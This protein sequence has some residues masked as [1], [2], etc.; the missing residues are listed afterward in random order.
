M[1]FYYIR[2]AQSANNALWDTTGASKG[3]N[4][5]PDITDTGREQAKLLADF[6]QRTD[7]DAAKSGKGSVLKRDYF[8]FTHLYTSLMLR[9]VHTAMAVAGAVKLQL[10][11]WP[12]I[13]ET[14]GIFLE[15]EE[16]GEPRGLPGKP[17]SFFA[18][19]FADLVLPESVTEAGWWNRGFEL[20]EERPL[21]AKKVLQVLLERHGGTDDCV[22]V[23][24]HG[25][26]YMYLIREI[27]GIQGDKNW[28]LM[29]N[30]AISRIDFE[31]DGTPM[32]IYHNRT[33]HLPDGLLT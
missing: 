4:E 8:G 10:V 26:F 13:H 20:D 25:A 29:H 22:A 23:V 3:R 7:E 9:S 28:F 24:S 18:S 11:A 30:T 33:E 6:I 5:D 21:R 19:Q 31:P 14:G 16:T 12:E 27:F 2:H 32:M 1:R 17:R 15:D